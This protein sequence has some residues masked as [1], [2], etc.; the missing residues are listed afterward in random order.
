[1][2]ELRVIL[3]L[4]F[5]IA[6]AFNATPSLSF[7]SRSHIQSFGERV[8]GDR[9]IMLQTVFVPFKR[10]WYRTREVTYHAPPHTIITQIVVEDQLI[11]GLGGKC[12]IVEG[13]PGHENVTMKFRSQMN[14]EIY[15]IVQFYGL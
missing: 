12:K 4:V 11:N 8:Y 15:S 10:A 14:Q 9:F 5:V 3:C 2:A 1:M 13:G 7:P 6:L